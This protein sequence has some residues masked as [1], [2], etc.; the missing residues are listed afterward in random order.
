MITRRTPLKRTAIKRKPPKKRPGMK[1]PAYVAWVHLLPC[2][3]CVKETD[4]ELSLYEAYAVAC[5]CRMYPPGYW[6]YPATEAAHVGPRGLGQ[7][8]AD[9]F[10]VPLCA[11]HHRT[12]ISAQ[13]KIGRT[14]WKQFEID[15]EWVFDTLHDLYRQETGRE[16]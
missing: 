10:V 12:G 14:F 4:G 1:D 16:V 2:V 8:C 11:V 3:A 15:R 9:K 7:R 13:H 5:L 6:G